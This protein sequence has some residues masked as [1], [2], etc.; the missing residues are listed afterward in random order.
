MLL[1]SCATQ[2][3]NEPAKADTNTAEWIPLIKA[4][5]L[6]GW[7]VRGKA[8]WEVKDGVLMGDGGM[9]H[10]YAD[11]ILTDLEINFWHRH[12]RIKASLKEKNLLRSK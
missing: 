3:K 8:T 9:G 12:K 5:S 2:D 1:I 10:I 6:D 4:N 7:F 11:P